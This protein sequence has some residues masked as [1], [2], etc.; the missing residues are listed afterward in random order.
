MM[1][2]RCEV[3]E[4]CGIKTDFRDSMRVFGYR[5][6]VFDDK[7]CVDRLYSGVWNMQHQGAKSR[8]KICSGVI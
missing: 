3:L 2:L 1:P 7:R 5:N 6:T 8:I 4:N